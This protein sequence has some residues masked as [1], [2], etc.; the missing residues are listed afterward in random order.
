MEDIVLRQENRLP[1]PGLIFLFFEI[2]CSLYCPLSS[3]N[4][5]MK[6]LLPVCPFVTFIY[7]KRSQRSITKGFQSCVFT[8][9]KN[10]ILD[11]IQEV[12]FRI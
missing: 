5:D 1:A 6:Y 8:V 9:K 7:T 2:P 3:F 12:L 4:I 11:L 10:V